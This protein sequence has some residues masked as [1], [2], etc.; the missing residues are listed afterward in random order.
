MMSRLLLTISLLLQVSS[1]ALGGYSS[2]G[3][4]AVLKK[5]CLAIGNLENIDY[6]R[7]EAAN[8]LRKNV[9]P[10]VLECVKFVA[11]E[12]QDKPLRSV[13]YLANFAA[14]V[15]KN[16]QAGI[17]DDTECFI[18]AALANLDHQINSPFEQGHEQTRMYNN[19][20][21]FESSKP[22]QSKP[23]DEGHYIYTQK[24]V[25]RML[26]SL[27]QET[28]KAYQD[29]LPYYVVLKE[30]AKTNTDKDPLASSVIAKFELSPELEVLITPSDVLEAAR[31]CRLYT[32]NQVQ[33]LEVIFALL[34]TRAQ[35]FLGKKH[36][37]EVKSLYGK[38]FAAN[39]SLS[40]P[41][42]EIQAYVKQLFDFIVVDEVQ[43]TDVLFQSLLR[44]LTDLVEI[45]V[46][47]PGQSCTTKRL[48][49]MDRLV[50][51][52]EESEQLNVLRYVSVQ[53]RKQAELCRK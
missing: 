42:D 32:Q 25:H 12:V 11:S 1:L 15:N 14:N 29:W 41:A 36:W 48:Q 50:A 49:K 31:L 30:L 43:Q 3:R 2:D 16:R 27:C 18:Q 47:V 45:A 9:W 13:N 6:L 46:L 44:E 38:I 28:V 7:P 8:E 17:V 24:E 21:P 26:S 10:T 35:G 22:V 51:K 53:R 40:L 23:V 20:V 33:A 52:Y 5:K 19:L 37:R 4:D 39:K 34:E